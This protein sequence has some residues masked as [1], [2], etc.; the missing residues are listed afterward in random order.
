MIL[1][2]G[3]FT[4]AQGLVVL[5]FI[6]VL[7]MRAGFYRSYFFDRQ[8]GAGVDPYEVLRRTFPRFWWL[9]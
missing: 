1:F 3:I 5:G 7:W 2:M 8:R 4:I 6:L 9:M